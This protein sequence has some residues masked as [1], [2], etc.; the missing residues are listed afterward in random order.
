MCEVCSHTH[1]QVP[2]RG[3][4]TEQESVS[5]FKTQQRLKKSYKIMFINTSQWTSWLRAAVNIKTSKFTFSKCAAIPHLCTWLESFPSADLRKYSH[6]L[7]TVITALEGCHSAGVAKWVKCTIW[8][9]LSC[10]AWARGGSLLRD[11]DIA[12][13]WVKTRGREEACAYVTRLIYTA[14]RASS[15]SVL[16]R[17]GLFEP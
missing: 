4:I 5:Y 2:V 17:L 6:G 8:A 16:H 14:L 11:L 7:E 12:L 13:G 3:Q 15:P 9:Q 1:L 10:S